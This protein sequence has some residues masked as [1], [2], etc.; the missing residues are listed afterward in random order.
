M[1]E[2]QRGR[3]GR[4]IGSRALRRGML[5]L[6]AAAAAAAGAGPAAA[7]AGLA[8]AQPGH[9]ARVLH[10]GP[11]G[12]ISTVAGGVGGPARATR[13]EILPCGLASD[14]GHLYVT[15]VPAG[16]REVNL[17][18]DGLTTPAG[19]VAAGGPP[20]GGALA[21]R[22]DLGGCGV[23]V[24][25][26]G[27]LVLPVNNRIWVVATV[28]GSFYGKPMAAGHIYP[29][30]GSVRRAGFSGDGGPALN[31]QLFEPQGTAV[32]AAGNLL[33]ADSG[34]NRIRVVAESTGTFY[35]KAMTAGNIYTVAG[36]GSGA[37]GDGG[38]A[39]GASLHQ[40]ATVRST[41][42][43]TWSSPTRST[44]G[45]GWW[46]NAPAPSTGGR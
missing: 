46:Q 25:R 36:G 6:M 24:D 30:A 9:G 39:L 28:S 37:L 7:A 23:T 42:R 35:G 34:N 43:A 8:A 41:R 2:G 33:L 18:S 14:A 5:A 29:V 11:A 45:S 10:A 27:N 13:V 1:L 40:P 20:V 38:P 4:I 3:T 19:P 44:S 21:T 12:V 26:A 22:V 16:V 32:D 31:A 17:S 15:D